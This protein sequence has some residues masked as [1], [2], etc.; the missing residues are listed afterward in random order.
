MAMCKNISNKGSS[1]GSL[2]RMSAYITK[3]EIKLKDVDGNIVNDE[4]GNPVMVENCILTEGVNCSDDRQAALL[5]M[6]ATK[7]IFN[8]P[9]GREALHFS[10]SF[11]YE[12]NISPEKAMKLTKEL[13][14]KH[15]PGHEMFLACH[16]GREAMA[17]KPARGP[18]VHVLIN[19]VNMENGVK[20]QYSGVG[21]P[22]GIVNRLQLKHEMNRICEREGL[23]QD[24]KKER[25]PNELDTNILSLKREADRFEGKFCEAWVALDKSLETCQG[26]GFKALKE[27]MAEQGYDTKIQGNKHITF[28]NKENGK[29]V[30]ADTLGRM[31]TDDRMNRSTL[32]L[33][34]KAPEREQQIERQQQP[35]IDPR[36][37][38]I[39][40]Y[41]RTK[42]E[43]KEKDFKHIE[44]L[45]V[46]LSQAK[47]MVEVYSG[48]G[49]NAPLANS[50]ILVNSKETVKSLEKQIDT[51]SRNFTEKYSP[52]G[53][54]TSEQIRSKTASIGKDVPTVGTKTPSVGGGASRGSTP[55]QSKG[56]EQSAPKGGGG[57]GVSLGD[58]K[59]DLDELIAQGMDP[60][61]AQA[62]IDERDG[63]SIQLGGISTD[64]VFDDLGIGKSKGRDSFSR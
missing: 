59:P 64:S 2:A 62:M 34:V 24:I 35:T 31:F 51:A 32:E 44:S 21:N 41:N 57:G 14:E 27:A 26:R 16:A 1:H 36:I 45:K 6:Q 60:E 18:H 25:L 50:K 19:T 46:E 7:D 22:K 42:A 11:S 39:E 47:K 4:N 63:I 37:A 23:S 33:V 12:D 54:Q 55:T 9:D 52:K 53:I 49:K 58:D 40:R 29:A 56:M 5:Q 10:N 28:T 38:E 17:G 43:A 8:K 3:E 15:Y 61:K 48:K 13:F 30:R 20:A